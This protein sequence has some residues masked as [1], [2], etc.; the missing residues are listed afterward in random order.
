M[1]DYDQRWKQS[2]ASLVLVRGTE[3]FRIVPESA[4]TSRIRGLR[5]PAP[6]IPKQI[7]DIAVYLKQLVS[8]TR[9]VPAGRKLAKVR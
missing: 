1:G 3:F 7:D 5:C 8:K 9:I 4:N 2:D 6:K